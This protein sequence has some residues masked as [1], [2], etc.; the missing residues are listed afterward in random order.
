MVERT[1]VECEF[2][3]RL[4]S[5]SNI[6]KHIEKHLH[7]PEAFLKKSYS[8]NHEGLD[9][10][11][12]GKTCKNRNS[13]CNHERVCKLNPERMEIKNLFTSDYQPS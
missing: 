13:L 12:C 11:F 6:S 1:K 9:C 2:C 7:K 10:Q 5:I 3:K 8:L 4:I